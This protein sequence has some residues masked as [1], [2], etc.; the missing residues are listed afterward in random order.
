MP[1]S[2]PICVTECD[3]VSSAVWSCTYTN[4]LFF[5]GAALG[6]KEYA[7]FLREHL[8]ALKAAEPELAH[9]DRVRRAA[10]AWRDW[11]RAVR[12]AERG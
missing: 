8:A 6:P 12:I 3:D 10:A 5:A 2:H 11:K 4:P 9:R 1:T 7:A